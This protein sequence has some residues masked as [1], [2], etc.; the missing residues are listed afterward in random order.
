MQSE[1]VLLT[2]IDVQGRATL[3]LHRPEVH[4]VFDERLIAALDRELHRLAEDEAVRVVV[5]AAAGKSFCAGGDLNW[6]RRSAAFTHEENVADA[7]VLSRMLQRLDTLPKPTIARVQGAAYGGGVGLIACCDMA[8]AVEEATFS[9]SEVRLGLLPAVISPF[10]VPAMG[11]RA[12]RRY[13]LSAERFA[14]PEACRL[15]LVNEVV[16][17]AELDGR[18]DTLVARLLQNGPRAMASAKELV[19]RIAGGF[20][21]EALTAESAE[22]IAVAR[23]GAEGREGVAAF[24]EK[25]PAAWLK[26]S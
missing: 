15:G 21:G 19:A 20:S 3:T 2:D 26:G 9:L 11:A 5:L 18:I 23:A 16:A 1:E 13:F 24:L 6:M 25:R 7:L 4:N 8:I 22:R 14:A 12:A 10:V 17:A